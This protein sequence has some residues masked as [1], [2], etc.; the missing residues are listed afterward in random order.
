MSGPDKEISIID[1][2][3][4]YESGPVLKQRPPDLNRASFHPGDGEHLELGEPPTPGKNITSSAH[5]RLLSKQALGLT[6]IPIH[7]TPGNTGAFRQR[8]EYNE[9]DF[10]A[11]FTTGFGG[12]SELDNFL[13][14]E[15]KPPTNI[16]RKLN[17]DKKI[18]TLGDLDKMSFQ[19]SELL[20]LAKAL[21]YRGQ[22]SF[23]HRVEAIALRKVASL[24]PQEIVK[25]EEYWAYYKVGSRLSEA[26]ADPAN[27]F[28][29]STNPLLLSPISAYTGSGTDEGLMLAACW[30]TPNQAA[31]TKLF[32]EHGEGWTT[33]EERSSMIPGMGKLYSEMSM[34][35]VVKAENS[36]EVF[37]KMCDAMLSGTVSSKNFDPIT[38]KFISPTP[39]PS[40]GPKP[41]PKPSPVTTQMRTWKDVQKKLNELYGKDGLL[42]SKVK[43]GMIDGTNV[44]IPLDEDGVLGPQTSG[45]YE[46]ATGDKI[47][48]SPDAA[49]IEL[50]KLSAEEKGDE[51]EQ[52]E[53]VKEEEG[54]E[55]EVDKGAILRGARLNSVGSLDEWYTAPAD[56]GKTL[57]A[58]RKRDGQLAAMSIQ[59][60]DVVKNK[61]GG[62]TLTQSEDGQRVWT[63]MENR[64]ESDQ[65][66][67]QSG[68]DY[69]SGREQRGL[70]KVIRDAGLDKE[71]EKT[72]RAVI[73]GQRRGE[74]GGFLNLRGVKRR[75]ERRETGARESLRRRSG[76]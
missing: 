3:E 60:F 47:G 51:P 11:Q 67:F 9:E 70:M 62:H 15:D 43:N 2:I 17:T 48:T 21:R 28:F 24:S 26:A 4:Y 53:K 45:A 10:E 37:Q 72:Y 44:K 74:R 63:D 39:K 52:A 30:Y 59:T 56:D 68:S 76:S 23:A 73:V 41:G 66:L 40:P 58:I 12:P 69:L 71:T 18:K 61:E 31:V 13:E 50:E 65:I 35:D 36:D 38:G 19:K 20:K 7:G 1:L 5:H 25:F 6:D 16:S 8:D 34:M 14:K 55:E 57:V 46:A 42:E 33:N 54:A 75:G 27:A 64:G 22:D 32:K 49:Y 29:E